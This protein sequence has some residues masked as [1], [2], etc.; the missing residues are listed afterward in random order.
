MV[1]KS[2]WSWSWPFLVS[3]L[4]AVGLWYGVTWYG[5]QAWQL[6]LVLIWVLAVA[7]GAANLWEYWRERQMQAF[8]VQHDALTHSADARLFEEARLLA[9]QSPELAGEIAHRIGRPDL[10]LFPTR[11][12][13]RA[14]IKVAGTDVTLQFAIK[15]LMLSDD[16]YFCAQRNFA[17][18]T[19]FYDPN[20][21][22]PDRK[23][24]MQLNWILA[25]EGMC[26]RYVH[27]AATNTAPM[28][29]PPWT[30]ARVLDNWI[31]PADLLDTLKPYLVK[32]EASNG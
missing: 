32:D 25:R 10:I 30:P 22:I 27:G 3:G 21:E 29:L 23:Q 28:W 9:A 14:Q 15:A 4:A 17:D 31:L 7:M 19:Y 12:G 8:A 26:T 20:R 11:A 6:V 5:A 2:V 24:W 1:N 16:V 13:K 18:G